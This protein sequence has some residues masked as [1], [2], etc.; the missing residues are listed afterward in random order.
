MVQP[1]LVRLAI[2]VGADVVAVV[3]GVADDRVVGDLQPVESRQE[4]AHLHVE[5]R[6]AGV[7]VCQFTPGVVGE[8]IGNVRGEIDRRRI[9]ALDG[10]G[11]LLVGPMRRP[12][13]QEQRKRVVRP[14][15][16][17]ALHVANRQVGLDGR[18]PS[19]GG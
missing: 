19:P 3:R 12:P 9:V 17:V 6:A 2:A 11:K 1:S 18:P 8:G 5:S 7:V 14:L 10:V 15:L 16:A 13:R 4:A